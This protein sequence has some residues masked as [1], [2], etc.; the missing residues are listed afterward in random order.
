MCEAFCGGYA[1]GVAMEREFQVDESGNST[2][3]LAP[4][5]RKPNRNN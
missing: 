4:I 1:K 5:Q 2:S 3:R